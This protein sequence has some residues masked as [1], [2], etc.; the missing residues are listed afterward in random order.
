MNRLL[1]S[2]AL[3]FALVVLSPSAPAVAADAVPTTIQVK[4]MHCPNCA[5]SIAGK[6]YAVPGVVSVK[7]DVTK[8]SAFVTPQ[9]QRQPSARAMWDAVVKAGFTPVKITTP[10]GSFTSRPEK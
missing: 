6:L 10:A 9:A 1:S 8:E 2:V 3:M 5:K 4:D 7:M